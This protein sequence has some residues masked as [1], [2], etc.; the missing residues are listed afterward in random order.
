M[1]IVQNAVPLAV[2]GVL[3]MAI[4]LGIAFALTNH[5]PGRS[6]YDE[7]GRGGLLG[8]D[9]P[10]TEPGGGGAMPGSPED[11]AEREREIRQMLGARSERRLARGEPAL[12][13]DAE[14]AGL[15]SPAAGAG[16]GEQRERGSSNPAEKRDPALVEE[17][18]QLVVAR[19]ERRARKGL[20]PFEVE[21]EVRRRLDELG[22]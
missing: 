13:L 2:F 21:A 8:E 18:R 17:V 7:I 6:A 9:E 16:P 15:L 1:L 19:N 10:S 3:A 11:Q 22:G 5:Q 20:E 14:L 4:V 12:D